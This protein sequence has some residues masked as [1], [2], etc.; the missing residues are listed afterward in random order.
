MEV[1]MQPRLLRF[2]LLLAFVACSGKSLRSQAPPPPPP[3]GSL[4]PLPR[5]SIAAVL[6]HR[7]E[8]ALTPDQVQRLEE[9]DEKL[10]A[11]NATLREGSA[12]AY[13]A[14]GSDAGPPAQGSTPSGQRGGVNMSG[15]RRGGGGMGM[16]RGGRSGGGPRRNAPAEERSG[17]SLE[18]RMDDNDTRA[19]LEAEEQVLDPG[20]RERARAIA[21]EY[22]EKLYDRREQLGRRPTP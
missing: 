21:E 10:A 2:V 12:S 13:T 15:G 18:Q 22:R 16:G 3:A 5:S 8:L 20:Q 9:Y 19:Y 4:P 11:R 14:A 7:E 17:E 6:E 1:S